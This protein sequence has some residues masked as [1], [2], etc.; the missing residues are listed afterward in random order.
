VRGTSGLEM[1]ALA[2]TVITAGTGRYEGNGFTIDPGSAQE[3]LDVLRRLDKLPPPTAEQARLARRYAHAIFV[4]KPYTIASLQPRLRTGKRDV[5]A[6]DD[7]VY[8]PARFSSDDLPQDLQRFAGW[9]L[10][11]EDR[12]LLTVPEAR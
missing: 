11:P 6:S 7:L 12:D 3:Y 2:K 9:A 8:V 10:K 4:M 5:R 1:A